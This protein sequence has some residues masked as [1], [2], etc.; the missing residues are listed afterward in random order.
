MTWQ[1]GPSAIVVASAD[2]PLPPVR[3]G[4][5][6]ETA[7]ATATDEVA[8]VT[9]PANVAPPPIPVLRPRAP[10]MAGVSGGLESLLPRQLANA[11]SSPALGYAPAESPPVVTAQFARTALVATR[12]EKL[13]F[14]SVTQPQS[15]VKDLSHAALTRPDLDTFAT[16]IPKPSKLVVM[17]FGVSAYRDLRTEKFS[18]SAIKPLRTAS[19]VASPDVIGR[20]LASVE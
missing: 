16:L 19:F 1:T 5:E 18:G 11:G 15:S 12:F 2:V 20:A 14:V 6:D 7:A 4:S 17:R 8:A 9:L 10:V 3:P 13:D